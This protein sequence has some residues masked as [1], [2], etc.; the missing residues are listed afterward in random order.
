MPAYERPIITTTNS[1]LP[2]DICYYQT[3]TLL[4]ISTL[5]PLIPPSPSTT[6]PRPRA[7]SLTI[8]ISANPHKWRAP[9]PPTPRRSTFPGAHKSAFSPSTTSNALDTDVPPLPPLSYFEP[10]TPS[11][12]PSPTLPASPRSH[13]IPGFSPT[14]TSPQSPY[15]YGYQYGDSPLSLS[16]SPRQAA[17][18]RSPRSPVHLFSCI[19]SCAS[20]PMSPRFLFPRTPPV[21]PGPGFRHTLVR[22]A[23]GQEHASVGC[24]GVA[25]GRRHSMPH[26]SVS[27]LRG[28]SAVLGASGGDAGATRAPLGLGWLGLNS[29]LGLFLGRM[30]VDRERREA[31][32]R[33][34]FKVVR[35][36]EGMRVG[37][38]VA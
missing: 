14:T 36:G 24:F 13:P 31:V 34:S 7:N 9:R 2:L 22:G 21:P 30:V 35:E 16:P 27:R 15:A 17:S 3:S 25:A 23:E 5:Y 6:M 18:L 20:S 28:G 29:S 4:P 38:G 1:I 12:P 26:G 33:R 19:P 10:D 8:Y 37:V 32:R 11:P